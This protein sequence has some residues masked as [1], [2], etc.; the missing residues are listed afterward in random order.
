MSD[1][2]ITRIRKALIAATPDNLIRNALSDAGLKPGR[3][4][5]EKLNA[6]AVRNWPIVEPTIW[7]WIRWARSDATSTT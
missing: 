3:S 6:L 7:E 2:G 5:R 1:D 4:S